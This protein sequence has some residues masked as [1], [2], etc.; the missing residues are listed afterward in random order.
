VLRRR[1]RSHAAAVVPIDVHVVDEQEDHLVDADQWRAL[2]AAVLA[3]ERVT[4]PGEANVLFVDEPAMADLNQLHMGAA[5]STD[6]LSFPI[7]AADELDDADE[8]IVGDIVICPAVAFRNAPNHAGTYPDE[9]ALLLVHGVL[10]LL[11]HD[12]A[13]EVERRRM[14]DRERELLAAHWRPLARDPWREAG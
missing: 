6:V 10:H 5:G 1:P 3:S 2:V 8:R 4:G 12:H 14:W 13:D 11:G 7:D 9:V